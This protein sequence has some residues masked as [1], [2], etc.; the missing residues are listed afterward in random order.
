MIDDNWWYRFRL[1]GLCQTMF[2]SGLIFGLIIGVTIAILGEARP[3]LKGLICAIIVSGVAAIGFLIL[4]IRE[5]KSLI[6][7]KDNSD[8]NK[9]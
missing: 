9:S 4:S 3:D 5:Y 8:E 1:E 6:R 7:R 2:V